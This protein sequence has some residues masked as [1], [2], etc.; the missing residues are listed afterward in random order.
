MKNNNEFKNIE[1]LIRNLILIVFTSWELLYIISNIVMGNSRGDDEN[2]ESYI[3]FHYGF[4]ESLAFF[5]FYCS[6][7]SSSEEILCCS[8]DEQSRQ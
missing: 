2:I 7:V 8:N 4:C 3:V 6:K 1:K 5:G